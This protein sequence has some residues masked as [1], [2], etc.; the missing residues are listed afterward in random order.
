MKISELS[1][2]TGASIRSIRYYEQKNLITVFRLQNGYR[3]Y[4]ET[5]ID[6]I[7]Q[8]KA[9][10]SLGLTTEQIERTLNCTDSQTLI[11]ATRHCE[12]M[13]LEYESYLQEIDDTIKK[14]TGI[15]T[16]LNGQIQSMKES[17]KQDSHSVTP[18]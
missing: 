18:L 8:I 16:E 4:D 9:Y 17:L 10:L 15:R 7:K 3:V 12:N 1:K 5:A 14:L 6:R 13:L 2:R 11:D